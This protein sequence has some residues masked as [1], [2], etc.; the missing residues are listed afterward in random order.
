MFVSRK[1]RDWISLCGSLVLD[2]SNLLTY[3]IQLG[4]MAPRILCT[5][6]WTNVIS[7]PSFLPFQSTS[8]FRVRVCVFVYRWIISVTTEIMY[9]QPEVCI[10]WKQFFQKMLGTV[11]KNILTILSHQINWIYEWLNLLEWRN[12]YECSLKLRG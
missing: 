5:N 7:F 4:I 8:L 2:T 10:C 11:V 9:R 3:S 12:A 6:T 1:N